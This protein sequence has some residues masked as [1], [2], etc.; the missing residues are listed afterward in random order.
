MKKILL[1]WIT[2]VSVIAANSQVADTIPD[3]IPAPGPKIHLHLDKDIYLPGETVWFKAYLLSNGLPDTLTGNLFSE[4][5]TSSGTRISGFVSPVF[6]GTSA[7]QFILPDTLTAG[8]CSILSYTRSTAADTNG[9]IYT[10]NIYI[11]GSTPVPTTSP[12]S[13]SMQLFAE[14]GTL[15]HDVE[16]TIAFKA[17][18]SNGLPFPLRGAIKDNRDRFLDSIAATHDGMGSFILFPSPG[19]TYYVEWKDHQQKTYRTSLPSAF[20]KG[21]TL[22]VTQYDGELTY[23]IQNPFPEGP[24]SDL[25]ISISSGSRLV[26]AQNFL[27]QQRITGKMNT[28]SIPDGVLQIT[29]YNKERMPLAERVVFINNNYTT[30]SKSG[31]RVIE[32]NTSPRGLNIIEL[33][34]PDTLLHNISVAVC[35]EDMLIGNGTTIY[36]DILLSNDIRGYVHRPDQYFEENSGKMAGALDLVML[37][38]GWR[39]YSREE[40][41]APSENDEMVYAGEDYISFYGLV[42]NPDSTRPAASLISMVMRTTDSTSNAYAISPDEDGRFQQNGLVFYDSATLYYYFLRSPKGAQIQI[43]A[44]TAAQFP[45]L[46][47]PARV[48][49]GY[50]MAVPAKPG[51]PAS[52]F[53]ELLTARQDTFEKKA[54]LLPEVIVKSKNPLQAMDDKYAKLYKGDKGG[55]MYDFMHNPAAITKA[56]PVR[57]MFDWML[58]L[59]FLHNWFEI[60]INEIQAPPPMLKYLRADQIAFVKYVPEDFQKPYCS[61]IYIYLKTEDDYLQEIQEKLK[62]KM[63]RVKIAGYSPK[64]EFYHPDYS[65]PSNGS[66]ERKDLQTTLYWQ[67]VLKTENGNKKIRLQFHNNDI[68]TSLRVVAEGINSRGQLVHLETTLK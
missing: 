61:G 28:R 39:K 16:N 55:R 53:A 26:W 58:P 60:Y 13:V 35:D 23:L 64:K 3:L 1:F 9:L 45:K 24:L 21:V 51:F 65:I 10:K 37:T 4:L 20:T 48:S 42:T 25:Q 33:E 15:I 63:S 68:S 44:G 8:T 29:V 12:L 22:H 59:R 18:Y 47:D 40:I 67:P 38:N 30:S 2:G 34:L 57:Y 19:E 52:K 27:M 46:P 6:S 50:P 56:D 17:M 54:R 14:G 5:R 7:G 41:N 32:K 62:S 43:A 11:A 31:I 36:T 66:A 49:F